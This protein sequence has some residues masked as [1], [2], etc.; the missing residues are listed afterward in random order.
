MSR[1]SDEIE[2]CVLHLRRFALALTRNRDSADDLVQDTIERALSRWYLRKPSL[3][4][5]PWLF[6]ILRN[7]HIS[8]HRR[9]LRSVTD[10]NTD[11]DSVASMASSAE[12]Q[13][14]LKQV[15]GLLGQL[16]ED[17]RTS[18]LLVSVEGFSYAEAA[19]I[20]KIPPGTLM[21]RLSRGRTKL[22]ALVETPPEQRL[23]RVI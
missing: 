19:K 1:R 13:L 15:L 20:M 18:I 8:G 23:R 4:L 6:A 11:I 17:Q 16:P 22:R 2:S 7:L 3:P 21:S 10:D 14:E 5:R 9:G 12:D